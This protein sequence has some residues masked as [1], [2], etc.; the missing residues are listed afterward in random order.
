MVRSSLMNYISRKDY[1]QI[2]LDEM[3]KSIG[4]E[5]NP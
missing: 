3:V 1:R 5:E 4:Q 2:Y